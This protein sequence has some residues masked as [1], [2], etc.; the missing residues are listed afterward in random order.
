MIFV[1]VGNHYQGFDRLLKKV[2]EI[3]PRLTD[4][5]VVQKG[6]SEYCPQH[7]RYF[8]F[9]PMDEAVEFIKKSNLV[10]SHAGIGTI[11][12]CK[13]HGKPLIIFP[14]RKK[15]GEHGTDH[16]MEIA[17]A[18]EDRKEAHIHVIYEETRLEEKIKEI[19]KDKGRY[20]SLGNEG[21]SN[22]IGIIKTFIEK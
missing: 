8:D 16:Q 15:F 7:T 2:D 4:D 13:E 3:A 20:V 1:T 12:L 18:L 21:R 14:R 19:L 6:Y 11:I 9:V 22:L 10:I 5:I 17:K